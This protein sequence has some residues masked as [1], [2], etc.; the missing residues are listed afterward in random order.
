MSFVVDFV[1]HFVLHDVDVFV[2]EDHVYLTNKYVHKPRRRLIENCEFILDNYAFSRGV[3]IK[4]E[5]YVNYINE[6]RM[7]KYW[8]LCRLIIA[9]DAIKN[10]VLTIKMHR[11]F[12]ELISDEVLKKSAC[13]IQEIRGSKLINFCRLM[14]DFGF[15]NCAIP[16]RNVTALR[17]LPEI[18][19]LFS[20]V[21]VLGRNTI[22][23]DVVIKF[24][25]LINSID[26]TIPNEVK[27][28]YTLQPL[29]RENQFPTVQS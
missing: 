11:K 27:Q 19:N 12:I 25:N 21:H 17:Y 18:V 28:I 26:F 16:T 22:M 1:R 15:E 9:P 8:S 3:S 13:V 23:F 29:H 20:Y 5:D 7:S 4:V 10:P 24:A 14:R 2:D 6:L